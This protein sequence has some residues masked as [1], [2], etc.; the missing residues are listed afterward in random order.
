LSQLEDSELTGVLVIYAT[1]LE[2]G[3][4]S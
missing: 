4:R 2:G 1:K 3:R